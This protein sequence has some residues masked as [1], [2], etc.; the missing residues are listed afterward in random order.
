MEVESYLEEKFPRLID[1][2]GIEFLQ[3]VEGG[4]GQRPVFYVPLGRDGY[5]LAHLIYK[6]SWGYFCLIFYTSAD[7]E[8][9]F[10]YMFVSN[11]G[12]HMC[13]QSEKSTEFSELSFVILKLSF[14]SR[15][16]T[17]RKSFKSVFVQYFYFLSLYLSL[18]IFCRFFSGT[19]SQQL[20]HLRA[21][22]LSIL[23]LL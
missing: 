1:G 6:I 21:Q 2:E 5:M 3:A 14:L 15:F 4:G 22:I 19:K 20:L 8:T 23:S 16:P 10:V 11:M 9:E 7:T 18:C 17:Y 12:W 13:L